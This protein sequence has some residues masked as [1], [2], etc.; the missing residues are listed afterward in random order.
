MTTFII[1]LNTKQSIILLVTTIANL[2][3]EFMATKKAV[4]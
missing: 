3:L 4:S 1:E 2:I